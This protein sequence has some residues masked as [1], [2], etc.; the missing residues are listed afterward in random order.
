[1]IHV[2]RQHRQVADFT[3]EFFEASHAANRA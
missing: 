3:A 2:D 1:M